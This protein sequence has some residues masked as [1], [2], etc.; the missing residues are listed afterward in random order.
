MSKRVNADLLRAAA[1]TK[2]FHRRMNF[3]LAQLNIVGLSKNAF[4]RF[5]KL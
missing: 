5:L 4:R 1:E 3:A 2:K